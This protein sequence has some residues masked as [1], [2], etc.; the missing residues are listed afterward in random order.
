M[1]LQ[2]QARI[3]TFLVDADSSIQ[4]MDRIKSAISNEDLKKNERDAYSHLKLLSFFRGSI[5]SGEEYLDDV[6][7]RGQ[8]VL[9]SGFRTDELIE[10]LE[11]LSISRRSI[12][13]NFF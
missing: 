2:I 5:I 6:V 13:G 3:H 1:S 4:T 9:T 12:H 10:K 11:E 8:E 7:K